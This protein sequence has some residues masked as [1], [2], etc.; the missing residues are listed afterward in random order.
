MEGVPLSE[1]YAFAQYDGA[2]LDESPHP[3]TGLRQ[4]KYS[5]E[6]RPE[7]DGLKPLSVSA[8]RSRFF[9]AFQGDTVAAKCVGRGR[10]ADCKTVAEVKARWD[11]GRDNGT[12]QHLNI[13]NYYNGEPYERTEEF[14]R[15]EDFQRDHP[16]VTCQAVERVVYSPELLLFGTMDAVMR[17]VDLPP[18]DEAMGIYDWK[19]AYN[20]YYKGFRGAACTHPSTRGLPACN[21]QEYRISMCLYKWMA[22]R[23]YGRFVPEMALI[24]LHKRFA[25]YHRD[26]L[27]WDA[28]LMNEIIADRLRDF[29]V[30]RTA[31]DGSGRL[32][33]ITPRFGREPMPDWRRAQPQ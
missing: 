24:G 19:V 1:Q 23:Y 6:G 4:H 22:E 13:E 31:G 30:R 3:E 15:C 10:Y 29:L 28:D 17:Y 5:V 9:P 27:F 2:W 16:H 8:F 11:E 33:W 18:D 12:A 14:K 25:S 26:D 7:L 32:P 21:Y 20:M